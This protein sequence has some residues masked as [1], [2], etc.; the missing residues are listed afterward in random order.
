MSIQELLKTGAN[1]SV[2]INAF[3]LKEAFLQ[4]N[5]EA[6][7]AAP[8]VKEEAFLTAQETANKLGCAVSTL[9]RWNK[10]NYLRSI[11]VG[12]K[13]RYRESDIQKLMEG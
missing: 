8:V 9:W 1:V 10:N 7:Q 13:V 6:R 11:K 4:W 5:N 3:D 12:S 2:T